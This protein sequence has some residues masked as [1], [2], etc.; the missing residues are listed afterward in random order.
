MEHSDQ[1]E[2]LLHRYFGFDNFLDHQKEVVTRIASGENLCVVMPTG[3]GKSLCYQLPALLNDSYTLVI[4]PLIALMADQVM[5][6]QKRNIPAAYINSTVPFAGQLDA[7]RRAEMGE[8]KL[9]YVAP[10][11]LQTDFF[12]DFLL[13]TPPAM[14]VVDE[15]HCISEWGHDFRPSYRRIG[16]IAQR[17]GISRI[18]AFTATATPEVCEDIKVQLLAP[19]MQLTVAGFRRP[20]LSFKV[21]ACQGGK[22]AKLAIVRKLLKEKVS[23]ATI[24]YAATRQAVDELA[25]LP[26]VQKYHAG[27]SNEER[28]S[29]QDYFMNDPAPVLA[30]TNAFGMGIDRP[31]VRRVIHY[32]LPGSLEAYYQE[33]GRAGRDGESAECL[34][35]FS[36]A[37]RYIQNF[38]IDMNNPPPS[39]IRSLYRILRALFK[40]HPEQRLLEIT[41]AS[42]QKL[43]SGSVS[44][45]QINAALIILEKAGAIIRHTRQTGAGTLR[46]TADTARLKILHQEEK[47]QRSRFIRRMIEHFGEKLHSSLD[48]TVDAMAEICSLSSE[49]I[50]RV[51]N[52]LN[53]DIL[54]WENSFSG[55]AIELVDPDKIEPDI[56]DN[57]LDQ[58]RNYEQARLDAVVHYG[59]SRNC[60]QAELTGY[61]GEKQ[62]QWR[63][64]ICDNC[65]GSSPEALQ[66]SGISDSD[67]RLALRA[68][69]LLN[70][71]VGAGKLA[72]ILAGSRSA[73]I[74]A[75]NWHRNACFGALRKLKLARIEQLIRSLIS[76]G[77]LE[78]IERNGYPCLKLSEAGSRRLHK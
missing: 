11:R 12:Y 51:L 20:N 75:G 66:E 17:A 7:V 58:H 29:A 33:A 56:D 61:F 3:A 62:S 21:H 49:Q 65:I 76:S 59:S 25:V 45:G 9:L 13:R 73:A 43:V 16:A 69:E 4:S 40:E 35:L 50:R 52:A 22:E 60:R 30:A 36:Y 47:T 46:F 27:M 28:K 2:T 42:L 48:I 34:L 67:I 23:G 1:L 26:G 77:D 74:V 37:D 14:L 71:R 57:E 54:L 39:V 18:C 6:L 10:E 5:A 63:C 41:S 78:K 38:L 70:G 15:A 44:D 24:I 32:Q 8:L 55:R 31:D 64:G 72:Q 53:N 19:D 68:A